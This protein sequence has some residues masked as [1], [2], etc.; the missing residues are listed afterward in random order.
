MDKR[1]WTTLLLLFWLT[2]LTAMAQ[3]SREI[4]GIVVDDQAVPLI[5]ATITN[6]KGPADRETFT[7]IT[8]ANGHFKLALSN[9]N[10]IITSGW[11]KIV[12]M[13]CLDAE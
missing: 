6:V 5:G 4:T 1:R 10:P 8:D 9:D 12:D 7:A 11:G 2:M 3:G 13:T